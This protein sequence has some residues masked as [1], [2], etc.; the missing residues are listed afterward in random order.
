MSSEPAPTLDELLA[1]P[2]LEFIKACYRWLLGREADESGLIYYMDRI[3]T[4]DSRLTVAG[5]IASS[6]EA[7]IQPTGRKLLAAQ[8]IAA[9]MSEL[10]PVKLKEEERD[11]ALAALDRFLAV[12]IGRPLASSAADDAGDPFQYYLTS[13]IEDR[14]R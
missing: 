1:M 6:D 10:L 3:Q 11:V 8:V 9:R 14:S 4:G 12:L 5:N 2:P 7:M 13:V